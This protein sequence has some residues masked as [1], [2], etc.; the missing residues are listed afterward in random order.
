MDVYDAADVA[1][2]DIVEP[3]VSMVGACIPVLRV[4]VRDMGSTGRCYHTTEDASQLPD[5]TWP[6]WKIDGLAGNS[7]PGSANDIREADDDGSEKSI[8]QAA[9]HSKRAAPVKRENIIVQTQEVTVESRPRERR[10]FVDRDVGY[11]LGNIRSR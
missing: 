7:S 4:L 6:G 1:I 8:F 10:D 5:P 9:T 3:A 11:E 2:W